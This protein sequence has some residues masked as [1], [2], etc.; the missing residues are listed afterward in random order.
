[1]LGK[2]DFK[3][4]IPYSLNIFLKIKQHAVLMTAQVVIRKT[5]DRSSK[6]FNIQK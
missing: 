3:G 1:M 6:E 2:G 5:G 4:I